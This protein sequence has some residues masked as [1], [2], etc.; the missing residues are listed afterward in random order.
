M[1]RGTSRRARSGCSRTSRADS[2]TVRISSFRQ[3]AARGRRWRS[4]PRLSRRRAR[5]SASHTQGRTRVRPCDLPVLT[6]PGPINT[7]A[8]KA[9][10]ARPWS[11]TIRATRVA[12]LLVPLC[13]LPLAARAERLPATIY[14]TEH[15]LASNLVFK[16]VPD[17]R[18]FIWFATRE[19]LSRFDGYGFTNYGVD[20]GL[21]SPVVNDFLE[22]REGVYLV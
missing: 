17:S 11:L 4:R 15:G 3:P 7:D 19:G 13:A 1:D 10:P 20:D 16:V 2:R 12:G 21:P 18:G 8:L 5:S 6:A 22:T 14:T 9:M